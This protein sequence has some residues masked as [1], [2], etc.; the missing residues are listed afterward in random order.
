MLEL[1][2]KKMIFPTKENGAMLL[3]C[4][5]N[6]PF[7]NLYL[8]SGK[9]SMASNASAYAQSSRASPDIATETSCDREQM[10]I[11]TDPVC[12]RKKTPLMSAA[13]AK[14]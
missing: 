8:S 7:L 11:L 14:K 9:H 1:D 6:I 4:D 12:R 2:R 5:E 10:K 3:F 13:F